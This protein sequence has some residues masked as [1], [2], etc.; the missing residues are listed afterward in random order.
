L[1]R[2]SSVA[3]HDS[4]HER[5][6]SYYGK[7]EWGI[8][9]GGAGTR[10]EVEVFVEK[11]ASGTTA[12]SASEEGG[13]VPAGEVARGHCLA[14]EKGMLRHCGL[15]L[16]HTFRVLGTKIAAATESLKNELG[17]HTNQLRC[18][19]LEAQ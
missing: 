13:S 6:G 17:K 3:E 9:G 1:R 10:D 11:S 14:Q 12:A 18:G 8:T 16:C 7:R 5:G 4:Q 15:F 19:Q 2:A